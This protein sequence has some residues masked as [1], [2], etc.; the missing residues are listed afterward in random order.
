MMKKWFIQA[1]ASL[2]LLVS[3]VALANEVHIDVKAP[4]KNDG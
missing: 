1:F 2:T 3:G 4:I